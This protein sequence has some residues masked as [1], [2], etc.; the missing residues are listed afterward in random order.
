M[1]VR[2]RLPALTLISMSTLVIRSSTPR[3][4]G[5]HFSVLRLVGTVWRNRALIRSFAGREVLERNKGA[6]LGVVWNVAN[7]LI[8]LA[9]YTAVFGY[10][11]GSRWE[12]GDLPARLDFPITFFTGQMLFHVFA[13][14][15]NR[16]PT[17]VTSRPN[18]VRRVVFPLEILPVTVVCSSLVTLAISAAIVLAI[19]AI[20]TGGLHWTV[21]LLPVVCVPLVL[22]SLGVAWFL[23]AV[24]VFVRDV[25]NIVV[26]GTQLLMFMTPLFYRIDRIPAEHTWLRWIVQHNPL[27]VIVENGRRCVLWGE[28]LEWEKLGVVTGVGFVAMVCGFA[29]FSMLRRSMADVH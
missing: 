14:C 8:T 2:D 3:P 4:W 25:R 11:F 27:S 24:G 6:A 9:V 15:A 1:L 28:P 21:V 18:L 19:T 23:S 26:V 22:L 29:V 20:A 10:I 16:A 17:L 5:E 7:P 13:E 12:K